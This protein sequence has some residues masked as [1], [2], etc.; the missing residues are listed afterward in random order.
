M[1][2]YYTVHLLIIY[3]H[4]LLYPLN[5]FLLL[6]EQGLHIIHLLIVYTLIA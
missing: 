2:A 4:N 1:F 3:L 5:L 6:I